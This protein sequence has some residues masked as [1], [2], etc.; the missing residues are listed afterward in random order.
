M[1]ITGE[2]RSLGDNVVIAL[3]KGP[4]VTGLGCGVCLR[5]VAHGE[6]TCDMSREAQG[7]KARQ[8]GKA[9]SVPGPATADW[10]ARL[11]ATWP[12]RAY[13]GESEHTAALVT[14]SGLD[15]KNLFFYKLIK[16][17]E[18]WWWVLEK[19]LL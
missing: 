5:G 1:A 12:R 9:Q 17:T 11:A 3:R 10:C 4:G 14:A 16:I 18:L 8:A 6:S 19:A 2:Q 7:G 15:R 13:A